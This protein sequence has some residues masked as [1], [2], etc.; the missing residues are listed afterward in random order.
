MTPFDSI[1]KDKTE[2]TLLT[3]KGYL[4]SLVI[5]EIANRGIT[6]KAAAEIMGIEQPR[7]S[8]LKHGRINLFS[9][10]YIV[11]L[12]VKLDYSFDT[13]FTPHKRRNKAKL[14]INKK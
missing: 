4:A 7:V 13:E 3:I 1:A 8:D 5:E 10:D 12:L 6:Q 11:G 2:A 14:S 9:V